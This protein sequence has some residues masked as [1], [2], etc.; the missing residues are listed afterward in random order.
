LKPD[1]I[2]PAIAEALAHDGPFLIDLVI[3][4]QVEGVRSIAGADKA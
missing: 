4:N 1:Q 3:A 2:A